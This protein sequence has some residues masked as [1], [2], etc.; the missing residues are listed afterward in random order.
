MCDCLR[1]ICRTPSLLGRSL[2]PSLQGDAWELENEITGN[3]SGNAGRDLNLMIAIEVP[4][5]DAAVLCAMLQ[6]LNLARL[7]HA[8]SNYLPTF[9]LDGQNRKFAKCLDPPSLFLS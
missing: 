2:E 6:A 4:D 3:V 7:A 8:E 1:S 5:P 9:K